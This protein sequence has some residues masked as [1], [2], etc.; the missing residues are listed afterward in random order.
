M[1]VAIRYMPQETAKKTGVALSIGRIRV[2]VLRD[3]GQAAAHWR[4]I[5]AA[6]GIYSPYQ[7]FDWV[8]LWHE[9]VSGPAGDTPCIV[10]G[11]DDHGEPLFLWPFLCTK[12]GPLRVA[13]FFGG[14]HAALNLTLWRPDTARAFTASDMNAVLAE[15][16]RQ[17]PDLDFLMLSNQPESWRGIP[18]P[19]ALL[20]RQTGTEDNFILRLGRPGSQVIESEIS[21]SMRSRLRNRE[22]KL[23]KLEG[24]RYAR[25]ANAAEVE[26]FLSAFLSQKAAK[27]AALGLENVFAQPGVEDFIRAA[28]HAGLA[29]G[30]PVIELHAL[31]GGGEV[32]ALFSGIHDGHRFTL[33]FASHTACEHSRQSPGLILLQHIISGCGDRG[34]DVFDIGPGEANYKTVFC[35]E[36][37]PIFDSILPLSPRGRALAM[38]LRALFALKSAVKRN[39]ALWRIASA[40]RSALNRTRTDATRT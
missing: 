2:E 35:K 19:F 31:E 21:S 4:K 40:V 11:F 10:V 9:H 37:E 8:C 18:N 29:E 24:Y 39:P 30:K 13:S 17:Q 14:K 26:R 33:M 22:R 23:A 38:P 3:V 20:A 6:D 34:F 16:A 28:C 25:A 7:S 12:L 15:L 32:L 27:L 5:E 36:F 1:N